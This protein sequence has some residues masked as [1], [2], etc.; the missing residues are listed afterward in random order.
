MDYR[1]LV[2][3][4][5]TLTTFPTESL[6]S[7]RVVPQLRDFPVRYE[8]NTPPLSIQTN[9]W[10][11]CRCAMTGYVDPVGMIHKSNAVPGALAPEL[12]EC[13][14]DS[15]RHIKWYVRIV[16][17]L[18]SS[19]YS[20]IKNGH[21]NASPFVVKTAPSVQATIFAKSLAPSGVFT[22][23]R[24]SSIRSSGSAPAASGAATILT[25]PASWVSPHAQTRPVAHSGGHAVTGSRGSRPYCAPTASS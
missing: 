3:E 10:F 25:G 23:H 6:P 24:P 20:D 16:S 21:T 17:L 14:R 7:P 19:F 2:P 18:V 9:R 4:T 13:F 5:C 1:P 12:T 8:Y 11:C 15:C 22:C